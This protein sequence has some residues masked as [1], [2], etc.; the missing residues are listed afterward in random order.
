M[1][2]IYPWMYAMMITPIT[3]NIL[4]SYYY[5]YSG[6]M[7]NCWQ[8]EWK[9]EY[10]LGR[11]AITYYTGLRTWILVDY[12]LKWSFEL[13]SKE[14]LITILCIY[15]LCIVLKNQYQIF[16]PSLLFYSSY[17]SLSLS[18]QVTHHLF[19]YI[20]QLHYPAIAPIIQ[21]HCKEYQLPYHTLPNFAQALKAHL[22]YLSIMGHE[23]H[24]F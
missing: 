3:Y 9:G 23:H 19:P 20:S 8:S 14:W 10:G 16:T 4:S 5:Y 21:Q 18:L 24:D 12:V 11:N 1:G 7:A 6:K 22:Y 2:N 15:Y 13:P 17:L